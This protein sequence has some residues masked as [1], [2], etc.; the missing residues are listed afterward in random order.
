MLFTIITVGVIT[1]ITS[2]IVDKIKLTSQG[3]YV[4]IT[5]CD[6]GFGN[7][8]AKSLDKKGCHVFATC[9]TTEGA[10][11]LKKVS[12]DRL[13]TILMDVTDSESIK[14]AF[15]AVSDILAKDSGKLI[16]LLFKFFPTHLEINT[17]V[18]VDPIL[19]ELGKSSGFPRR[20]YTRV[21]RAV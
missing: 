17:L 1:S 19:H 12:S 18:L 20:P 9:L 21:L 14:V 4:L 10:E 11:S 15:E 7:L 8:L 13:H 3:R 5:G 6:T 16:Q 2:W